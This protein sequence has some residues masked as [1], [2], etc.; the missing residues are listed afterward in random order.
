MSFQ[1]A[2]N[3]TPAPGIAG[4]FASTNPRRNVIGGP[5]GFICGPNGVACGRFAWLDTATYSIVNNFGAG[6]PNGFVHNA[7]QALI[8]T[9]LGESSLVVPAGFMMGDLFDSGDFWCLNSTGNTVTPGLKVYVNNATGAVSSWAPTGTPTTAGTSTASTI[10]AGTSSVTGSIAI[11][12]AGAT[13]GPGTVPAV[14]TVTNVGSGTVYPGTLI[15]G[16][17][18]V[19]GTTIVGQLTGTIGGIGTYS[20][21]IPQTVASTTISGTYGLL[22]IG[23]T[24]VSGFGVGQSITAASAGTVIT[25]LGTGTGGAGTYIV[26]NTQTVASTAINSYIGTETAWYAASFGTGAAGEVIKIT[27]KWP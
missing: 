2:V 16:T 27:S 9:Y 22:T 18:V 1:T 23:G 17:G 5:G 26:N 14:L 13:I 8:T 24:V 6:Q 4:E 20:V 12:V 10:A 3:A 25:A 15:S 7:H 11:P 21:S 19:T